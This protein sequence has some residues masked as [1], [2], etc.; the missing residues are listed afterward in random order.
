MIDVNKL[1]SI[2][3]LVK[4]YD[5]ATLV[6]ATKTQSKDTIDELHR[7]APEAVMGENRAQELVAKYDPS[8]RWHMIGRLQTNK[9][10]YI[11][12]K[13]ELVESLDREELASELDR[14]AK[15]LNKKIACLVEV[16]VGG[17]ASKGGV[18]IEDTAEFVCGLGK[19][20]NIAVQGLM[21][22]MPA[23]DDIA[24]LKGY[25]RRLR[26]LFEEIKRINLPHLDVKYLSAGM[27]NDYMIALD[28]GAN[29]VRI[30][31]A[32]FGERAK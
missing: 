4:R 22:V 14:R 28:H 20:Q 2:R 17:E 25:Y 24:L 11:A 19:Y 16:N 27:T 21:S 6:A 32:I 26:A 3:D 31:R 1:N 12:D 30:G 8:M 7:L 29:I 13:V 10:K 15:L 9:V 23:T 5:G 18:A